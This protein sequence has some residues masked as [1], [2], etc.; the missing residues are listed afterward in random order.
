MELVFFFLVLLFFCI[1]VLYCG[2]FLF[3]S[4]NFVL[5]GLVGLVGLVYR[6]HSFQADVFSFHF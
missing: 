2:L 3:L 4:Y 6:I 1:F 5:P